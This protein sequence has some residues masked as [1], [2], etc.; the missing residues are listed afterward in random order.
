MLSYFT[1]L[2]LLGRQRDTEINNMKDVRLMQSQLYTY[3]RL[4]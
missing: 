3:V 2:L 1:R 4:L